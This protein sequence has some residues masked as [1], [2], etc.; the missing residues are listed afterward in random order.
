MSSLP[1][2]DI[3]AHAFHPKIAAKAVAQLQEH[4]GIPAIGGGFW[5]DMVP[6]MRKAGLDYS[7]VLS[8]ATKPEQV[9]P[10]NSYAAS[11][12]GTPGVI[13]FGTIHPDYSKMDD[14]L[15]FLWDRGIHGIKL[16]PD[17]Q[18]FRLDDPRLEPFFGAVEG[19]FTVLVHV[20]DKLPPAENPSCPFKVAA[21][22]RKFP[23]L[24]LIAAHFGGV[25]HWPYVV[26]ALKGLDIL[27]DTS[28][29]LFAI[30]QGLLEQIFH[31]FPLEN[32]LFGSD[33]PL[34]DC[35]DERILLQKRL[36]LSSAQLETILTN[37]NRLFCVTKQCVPLDAGAEA[38]VQ[39]GGCC[40]QSAV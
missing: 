7:S 15:A 27:M 16:H 26:E 14:V 13:P 39:P 25:W 9:E 2:I 5:E 28:S 31:S 35:A 11:L 34:F 8:A 32:F 40:R 33:Y 36:A 1:R 20:G 29:S 37:A 23:R 22:K 3:H 21:I 30:P 18:G 38:S 12:V 10:A 24:E 17:F 19:R 4:Y 6:R